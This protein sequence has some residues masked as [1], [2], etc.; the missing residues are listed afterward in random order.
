LTN[1]KYIT[2][3]KFDI[4]NK[5]NLAHKT[6]YTNTNIYECNETKKLRTQCLQEPYTTPKLSVKRKRMS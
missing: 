5:C 3:V 6:K 1:D 2:K 4:S